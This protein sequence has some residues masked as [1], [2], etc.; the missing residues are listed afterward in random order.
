VQLLDLLGKV[1]TNAT[2][3][4]QGHWWSGFPNWNLLDVGEDHVE[5]CEIDHDGGLKGHYVTRHMI[6]DA[7]DKIDGERLGRI[8]DLQHDGEDIDMLLQIAVFGKNKY[9]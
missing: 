2:L 1:M 5:V 4:G 3:F 7:F 8:V 6:L 9:A